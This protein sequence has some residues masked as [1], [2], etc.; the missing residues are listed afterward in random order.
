MKK[1]TMHQQI[2]ILFIC[3]VTIPLFGIFTIATNVFISNAKRDLKTIYTANIDEIGD[4]IDAFFTNALDLSLYPLMEDSLRI[5]LS[6]DIP[7]T[8]TE[9]KTIKQKAVDTLNALPYGYTTNI[10]G[11]GLYTESGDNIISNSMYA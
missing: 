1:I 8:S 4:N 2:I 5:Y 7:E 11:I 10:N 9:Y 3:L 6:N